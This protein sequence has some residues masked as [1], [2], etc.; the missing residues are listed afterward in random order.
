MLSKK[1]HPKDQSYSI[2]STLDLSHEWAISLKPRIVVEIIT[3][4]CKLDQSP[5][6]F[7]DPSRG[8]LLSD[9]YHS[10][11]VVLVSAHG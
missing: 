1:I 5:F 3:T 4:I 2:T 8:P 7:S 10:C 9:K 11:A 6:F